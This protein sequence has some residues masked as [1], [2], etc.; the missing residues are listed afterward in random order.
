MKIFVFATVLLASVAAPIAIVRRANLRLQETSGPLSEQSSRLAELTASNEQLTKQL[1]DAASAGSGGQERSEI[2][3]LRNEIGQLR[4]A[5]DEVDKLRSNN[6]AL[7]TARDQSNPAAD[8]NAPDPATVHAHW[9]KAQLGFAGYADP[10]AAL[11]SALWA[12]S[13]GDPEKLAGSVTRDAFKKLT[14]EGWNDR[15]SDVEEMADSARDISAS[16]GPA[17]AFSITT[18]KPAGD[19]VAIIGVYFEGEGQTR[20]IAMKKVDGEWKL[21]KM[22]RAG[23]NDEDIQNGYSVWP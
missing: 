12:M 18:Q 20:R 1:A 19:D 8:A 13:R 5:V 23:D 6:S 16:L 14:R 21:S 22:G 11:Q 7:H 10:M 17:I 9:E 3:K 2:L 15:K 4:R